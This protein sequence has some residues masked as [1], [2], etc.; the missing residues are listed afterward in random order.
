M[1]RRK[2]D[3]FSMSFLDVMACGLGAIVL[4]YVIING[5]VSQRAAEANQTQLAESS[6]L[7]EEV[8]EGRKDLIRVRNVLETKKAEEVAASGDARRLQQELE[9]L[10]AELAESDKTSIA[11]VDSIEQLQADVE[12]LE[13]AKQRLAAESADQSPDTGQQVRS[14]VGDGDRQY[15]T[16]MKMGGSHVLILVDASTSMLGRT[17]VNVVRFRSMK[18]SRQRQA[19]KWQQ[20]VNSVDWLTTR[21]SPGERPVFDPE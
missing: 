21:L 7:E 15:L 8:L 16:G 14:F 10:L 13:K 12:R 9:E 6:L 11:Q 19:P 3:L 4:M 5:Q 2:F 18:E 1:A 17:Y 20:V